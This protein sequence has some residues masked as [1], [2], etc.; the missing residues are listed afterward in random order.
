M[1]KNKRRKRKVFL[2]LLLFFF[3]Y[4]TLIEPNTL[5]TETI[6]IPVS[7]TMSDMTDL[8]IIQFS[9]THV[10]NTKK[11]RHLE[12]VI[13]KINEANAD[14]IFFTGDLIDDPSQFDYQTELIAV[15]SKLQAKHGKFA[16]YGNHDHGGY[17]TETYLEIMRESGFTLLINEDAQLTIHDIALNITGLDDMI[18]GRPDGALLTGERAH[19][20]AYQI[21]LAH[22]PDF[23]DALQSDRYDLM[24]AGHSHGGQIQLPFLDALIRPIGAKLYTEGIFDHIS[25]KLYVDTG[26]GT[27]RIPFRFLV[28]PQITEIQFVLEP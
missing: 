26:T 18:L 16:I 15:L 3:L 2:F 8:K 28:P 1:K 14:I 11:Q 23:V 22:E 12:K 4:I 10:K 21:L 20:H 13:Q 25:T 24:L 27:T 7:R 6:T 19:P 17:G 9:D 5:R